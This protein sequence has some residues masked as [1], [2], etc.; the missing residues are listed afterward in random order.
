MDTTICAKLISTFKGRREA[1]ILRVDKPVRIG[2]HPSCE[3]PVESV[4]LSL[5]HCSLFAVPSQH[6]GAIV[7]CQDYS[8]N[9]LLLNGF[10]ILSKS[11]CI[12]MHGD[13]LELPNGQVFICEH[14]WKDRLEKVDL[15]DPTPPVVQPTKTM[16][17]ENFLVSTPPGRSLVALLSIPS[18]LT[19]LDP[20]YRQVAVKAIR[21]KK[22]C[23]MSAVFKEVTILN[24]L[25]HPNINKIYSTQQNDEFMFI[26]L[27]LCTGGDLFTYITTTCEKNRRL[28]EAETKFIMYQLLVGLSYLHGQSISH[29]DLK[30]ENILLYAPGPY[31]RI[32]IGDFGLARPRAYEE[33]LN[34]CGT[35]SYLPPEGILALDN[36]HLRYT[37][38]PSDCWSA[39]VILYIMICGMHP[40]DNDRASLDWHSHIR[41]SH[42]YD[43]RCSQSYHDN[44]QCLKQRIVNHR[45]DY[46]EHHWTNLEDA[47]DLTTRLLIYDYNQRA[48]VQDAL[49]SRWIASELAL[50]NQTYKS[51]CGRSAN[52]LN[53]AD[54]HARHR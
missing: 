21:R 1:I 19:I 43:S 36:G 44:E 27:Q 42:D 35:I 22:Q 53:R 45:I 50:L 34:V 33:T 54:A 8:R 2:R 29:R 37:G 17:I 51:R 23:D 14:V 38:M 39:G 7:S 20:S 41:D 49:Q 24:G 52:T 5:H 3:Y 4:F 47:K 13:K 11:S 32:V 12:L 40:Y 26:F 25:D 46:Y 31:P 30:P 16:R 18:Y 10:R 6:G 9:G 15:F 48:T 28:C